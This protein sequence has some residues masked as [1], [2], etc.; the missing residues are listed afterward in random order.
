MSRAWNWIDILD[1]RAIH[2]A[3]IAR[4][5]GLDGLREQGLI[6]S[7]LA[8]PKNLAGYASP[9][10]ADLAAFGRTRAARSLPASG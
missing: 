10:A 4:H 3:Q 1:I 9:D 6:E 8:R 7:A 5:G 2:G